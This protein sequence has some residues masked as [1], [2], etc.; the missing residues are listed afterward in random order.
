MVKHAKWQGRF[1]KGGRSQH[2]ADQ[3]EWIFKKRNDVV[4]KARRPEHDDAGEILG[5]VRRL[6]TKSK[7]GYDISCPT[8]QGCHSQ[9]ATKEEAIENIRDA[10]R[11]YLAAQ[12]QIKR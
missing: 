12:P 5:A 10:I 2:F 6:L 8:L 7:Y 9:G 11:E 1:G 4:H 3:A